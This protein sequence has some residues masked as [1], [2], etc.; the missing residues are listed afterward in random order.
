MTL[1]IVSQII[2][3]F[4]KKFFS[5]CNPGWKGAT[6]EQC[7]PL[8]GCV[9]GTCENAWQCTC[10]QGWVGSQCDQGETAVDH[11]SLDL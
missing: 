9:H 4:K 8:H 5:R 1:D 6:C 7:I 10:E 3:T 11:Q 2:I